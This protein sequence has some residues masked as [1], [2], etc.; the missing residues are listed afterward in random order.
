MIHPALALTLVAHLSDGEPPFMS[1]ATTPLFDFARPDQAR[2]WRPVHDTVMG[3]V[4]SGQPRVLA[5]GVRFEGRVSLDNNGGFAT[6]RLAADLPDLSQHDGLRLRL[7]GD[8]QVYKLALRTDDAWDG[9]SWQLP[10]RAAPVEGDGWTTVDLAFEDL[11][12]S[13]RGRLVGQAGAFDAASIAQIGVLIADKQ[14][15]PFALDLAA[16]EAWR[17]ES[18]GAR[19]P[20][21]REAARARTEQL[22]DVVAAGAD[23]DTLAAVLRWN[24]RLLVVA[25]PDP[26]TLDA[27]AS[28]QLGAFLARRS[29]L[30]ERELRV[31]QLLGDATGRL[32]G[33][34]LDDDQVGGL[35][36]RWELPAERWAMALV[37]KDGGVKARWLHGVTPDEV[38]E[39][40]DAMPM[41]ATERA[42]REAASDAR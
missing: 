41:R 37:G 13:W 1:P 39:R 2:A 33:R 21:G 24:E 23:A 40:I 30:D 42:R 32:A 38:F 12:P 16:L 5:D 18:S 31:V 28:V 20:G 7:R 36:A 19:L 4:S 14:V 15:G 17:G 6:F 8:G 26:R 27:G 10:F 34:T 29:E 11:V 35:R 9:V 25:S 22:A 3:G